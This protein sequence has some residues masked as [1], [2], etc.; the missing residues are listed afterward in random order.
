MPHHSVIAKFRS[1]H[2][3]VAGDFML[4]RFISGTIE[5]ISPEA[6][7]PVLRGNGD[8][9]MLGGAGNVVAN[10]VAL[11]AKALPVTVIGADQAAKYLRAMLAERGIPSPGLFESGKRITSCKT[12]FVAQ[13]QQVLRYDEEVIGPLS[14]DE[15]QALVAAFRLALAEADIVILSDYG[16]GVLADG[17]AGELIDLTRAAGK[18]VLVDPKGV[19]Y[20]CYRGATAVTPNR[21]EL[22][23]ATGG[24]RVSNDSEIEA[25]GRELIARCG[26][27]FVLATR[28]EEGMSVI[29]T[30]RTLHLPTKAREVFDVSGAGDTVVAAYALSLAAGAENV[31]AAEIANAAAGVVVGKVGTAQASPAEVLE[32][33]EASKPATGAGDTVLDR[34]GISRISAIWKAEGLNVGFTN[35]CFDI[36]H[37]G[38][39]H[40]LK[41][42]R[43]RCDRLIVGVNSDAS[44]R[45]LKGDGR[46]ING[47]EE[48]ARMLAALRM[49]DAVVIFDEDTPLNLIKAIM[50]NLLAKGADYTVEQVVGADIVLAAGGQIHL[51]PL[52]DGR[53]T[54]ATLAQILSLG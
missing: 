16:K 11:G 17:V 38:H 40:Q 52:I 49:V 43:A 42:A 54:S 22:S 30:T 6:P 29:E 12:R 23:E 24:R 33:L 46:P 9:F 48:R 53:S 5:R 4:D 27:E 51:T 21:K 3:L 25:A 18:R 32:I 26:F 28:S 39:L 37:V 44:V 45:R 15:R 47:E 1:V 10:I 19:D 7:I 14:V 31:L 36:L 8:E 13:R 41:E 50:P 34:E 20:G 35:G 2:V